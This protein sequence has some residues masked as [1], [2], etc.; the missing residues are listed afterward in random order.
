MSL[1]VSIA[2]QKPVVLI[3]RKLSAGSQLLQR[4]LFP[5]CGISVDIVENA[6]FKNKETAID[7][8]AVTRRFLLKAFDCPVVDLQGTEATRRLDRRD[9]CLPTGRVVV[10]DQCRDIDIG[11][12][13]PVGQTKCFV[14]ICI[15]RHA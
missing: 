8:C 4:L 14:G 11:N 10:S 6:G 1:R 13:V 7:P 12:A 9:C 15:A 3:G 5:Y 2:C